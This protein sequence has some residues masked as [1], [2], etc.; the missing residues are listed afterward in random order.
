MTNSPNAADQLKNGYPDLTLRY[1][2]RFGVINFGVSTV[3]REV[4]YHNSESNSDESVLGWGVNLEALSK[5]TETLTIRGAVTH[6]DGLGGYLYGS[7]S[8]AGF[9]D[10]SGSVEGIKGIGG[11]VGMTISVGSGN[12]NVAYGIASVDLDDAVGQGAMS[13]QATDRA[14]SVYLNYIWSPAR[15]ISYGVEVGYHS[16]GTQSGE[17]GD[18]V[19]L[20]GMVQ[21]AF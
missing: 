13:S 21:Y 11:T 6:G 1:G 4:A 20:Q 2:N 7:P 19:R 12:V 10:A 5:V 9:I 18:A 3:L 14:E 15:P 17:E 16:R 8:G